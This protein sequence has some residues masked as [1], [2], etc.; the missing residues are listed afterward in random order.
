MVSMVGRCAVLSAEGHTA[1]FFEQVYDGSSKPATGRLAAGPFFVKLE[2]GQILFDIG[3]DGA[4][5]EPC[6]L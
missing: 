5:T 3:S 6:L 2:R 4:R 1:A